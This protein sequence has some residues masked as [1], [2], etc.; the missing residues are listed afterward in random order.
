[1]WSFFVPRFLHCK[2]AM[3]ANE[4]P[5]YPRVPK[6]YYRNLKFRKEVLLR[7]L[8][9]EDMRRQQISAC[10]R[11][12][13]YF[14][15]VFGFAFDPFITAQPVIPIVLYPYQEEALLKIQNRLGRGDL[16]VE[17]SRDMFAS[18]MM[19]IAMA[20]RWMFH[21]EQ[22]FLLGSRTE[23]YVDSN[24]RSLMWKLRFFI[25]RLPSWMQ[26]RW[27]TKY[28][29]IE[30]EDNNSR[31][32]GEATNPNFSRGG[33]YTAILLDEFAAVDVDTQVV[34]S[35]QHSSPCRLF[36]STPQGINN[37]FYKLRSKSGMERL[38]L[39][40]T[41]HPV[42]AA[43]LYYDDKGKP[44]SPWYDDQCARADSPM[45]IAQEL[46]IDYSGSD[47]MWFDQQVIGTCIASDDCRDPV[48][49]GELDFDSG[50]CQPCEGGFIARENG[51]FELWEQ[52]DENG[53]LKGGEWAMGIDIG[54]GIAGPE[55]SFSVI[56]FGRY[57]TGRKVG[58]F[59][60]REVQPFYLARIAIALARHLMENGAKII[61]ESN[62]T[63][64]KEFGHEVMQQQYYNVYYKTREDTVSGKQT[65][66][67]GFHTGLETKGA[68]LGEYRRALESGEFINPCQQALE[69][70]LQFV[71]D[72]KSVTH[73]LSRNKENQAGFGSNHGDHVIADA[74]LH[75][76]FVKHG[77]DEKPAKKKEIPISCMHR[78]ME[79]REKRNR[80][81][82]SRWSETASSKWSSA[83]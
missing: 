79:R 31:F 61:F 8:R 40:W 51:R 7:C 80:K 67:M 75:W 34:K 65:D 35:T 44:R 1:M 56:S 72:G 77:V 9:D 66:S 3:Q 68:L 29:L 23:P 76:E 28:M 16:L 71:Y 14:I 73:S 47:A 32:A 50:S 63:T 48:F 13:L 41:L 54:A 74:L 15:S 24:D 81:P 62:G 12:I 59:A 55:T 20:H 60:S 46:D 78:R 58:Q 42:F 45:E 30:N 5:Y 70:C 57:G 52:P 39:H 17:K 27:S 2:D 26:P 25:S 37:Q 82:L 22:S 4:L 6:H 10:R 18:W 38:T 36:N 43:G 33:R 53:K 69:Q 21:D 49:V 64:G 19:L 11:D 83:A